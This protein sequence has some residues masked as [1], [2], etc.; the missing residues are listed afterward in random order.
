MQYILLIVY[1]LEDEGG[2]QSRKR[3]K[4]SDWDTK[5]Q[6]QNNYHRDDP[7]IAFCLDCVK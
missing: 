5:E 3:L 1:F 2:L 4:G 7:Q 6:Y